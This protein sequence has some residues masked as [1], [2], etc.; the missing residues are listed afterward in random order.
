MGYVTARVRASGDRYTAYETDEHG[1]RRSLGTYGTRWEAELAL[2]TKSVEDA[3]LS[4]LN[5]EDWVER[6]LSQTTTITQST[7]RNYEGLLRVNVYPIMGKKKVR[8][9]SPATIHAAI[10]FM[11][12][13][14]LAQNSI[15]RVFAAISASFRP[16]TE[17]TVE[18]PV[19]VLPSSPSA[20]IKVAKGTDTTYPYVP[21]EDV[22][23]IFKNLPE[24]AGLAARLMV[25]TGLRWQE[26][27][28]LRA[29]DFD[30]RTGVL[31]ISR[32][33]ADVGE[34]LNTDGTGR[35]MIKTT[36]SG[37]ER[38]VPSSAQTRAL[39]KEHMTIHGLEPDD[40]L[41]PHALVVEN[42]S[43]DVAKRKKSR[44]IPKVERVYNRNLTGH[45]SKE[46]WNRI[47]RLA[48]KQS[49]IGYRVRTHDLRHAYCTWLVE[50]GTPLHEVKALA[51]HHSITITE[52][53]LHAVEARN[54]QAAVRIS[55]LLDL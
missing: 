7:K 33:I 1:K 41:F 42:S 11:E 8:D 12:Q 4:L 26:M 34:R 19:P 43:I 10:Q 20:A 27:A 51:G 32:A 18:R 37:K 39:L 6:W 17:A 46:S 55:D 54:S 9:I 3:D 35:W 15:R 2:T 28:E 25:E 44:G 38:M 13:R 36:K 49:G 30:W 14:G 48:V 31:T 50:S 22:K 52:R 40:L 53:Y 45:V 21:V 5:Y 24:V 29:K 23:Q 16:L 47:W